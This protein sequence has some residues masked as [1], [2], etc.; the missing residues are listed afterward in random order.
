MSGSAAVVGA[1]AGYPAGIEPGAPAPAT[2]WTDTTDNFFV[3]ASGNFSVKL[4]AKVGAQTLKAWFDGIDQKIN[5]HSLRQELWLATINE[6]SAVPEPT[7]LA[8]WSALGSL[9]MIAAR[10]RRKSA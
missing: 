3:Q 9:G 4:E 6:E 8:I 2:W 10:H 1:P 7:T 5:S